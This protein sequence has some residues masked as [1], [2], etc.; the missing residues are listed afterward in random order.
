MCKIIILD[1]SAVFREALRAALNTID[2]LEVV[3]ETGMPSTALSIAQQEMPDLVILDI[4]IGSYDLMDL[5]KRLRT[6]N[7]RIKIIVL[8]M[9]TQE[10]IVKNALS[11]GINAYVSK[12]SGMSTLVTAID[13]VLDG[14]KYISEEISEVLVNSLSQDNQQ[15]FHLLSDRELHI[16]KMLGK[17]VPI[18]K[19]AEDLKLSPKTISSHKARIKQKL[20]LK[21]NAELYKYYL[22]SEYNQTLHLEDA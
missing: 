13:K 18:A 11:V 3:G 12:S 10:H 14:H 4:T 17:G 21:S 19:I 2:K 9:V 6:K 8:S 1:E 20:Q 15:S 5:I 22:T 7:N 16:F